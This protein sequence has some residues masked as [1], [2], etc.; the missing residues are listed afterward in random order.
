MRNGACHRR[1][2]SF[3]YF[4]LTVIFIECFDFGSIEYTGTKIALNI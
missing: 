2:Y 4:Q 3:I 1:T